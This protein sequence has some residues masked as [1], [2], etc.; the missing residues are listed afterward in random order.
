MS[1]EQT[2][3]IRLVSSILAAHI[4]LP[5]VCGGSERFLAGLFNLLKALLVATRPPALCWA[6]RS[7]STQQRHRNSGFH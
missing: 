1:I 2:S 3:L 6:S 5:A 7:S 4:G